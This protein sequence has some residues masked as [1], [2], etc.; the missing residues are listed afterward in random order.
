MG[1]YAIF[2]VLALI[3][4][5]GT[6]GYGLQSTFSSSGTDAID[7]Y[8]KSQA[9]NIA[10]SAALVAIQKLVVEEDEAYQPE[11]DDAILIPASADSSLAS[12]I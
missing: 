4:S 8:N 1:R 5:L 11:E 10:Q 9:R 6:Y 3:I 2:I 12:K 7:F